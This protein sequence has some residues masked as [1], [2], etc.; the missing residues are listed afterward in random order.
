MPDSA[1]DVS[2]VIPT[3][4]RTDLLTKTVESVLRQTQPPRE[5]I[6]VD[7]GTQNRAAA[8]L[9][10]FGDKVRLARS[11]PSIKQTARNVGMK[12]A[13]STWVATLD[14][15]DLL[16]PDY[17][18]E[19][20][21]PMRDGRADI[22]SSDHRKFRDK[23]YETKTNFEKAPPGYWDDV[24]QPSRGETWAYVGK[25]PLDRLLKRVPVYPSTMI[26]RRDFALNIGGY[27]PGM[28]GIKAEDLEF[29]IRALTHGHLALVWKPL[30]HY[31][32]HAGNDSASID[33]QAIG[34][35][36]IFEFARRNHPDL[37]SDFVEA[38]DRNL[39]ERRRRVF[40]IAHRMQDHDAMR[41]LL[42]VLRPAD[43]IE[44]YK[45][46]Y[47]DNNRALMQHVVT[48]IPAAAW[49]V[50]LRARQFIGQLPEPIGRTFHRIM[51][52]LTPPQSKQA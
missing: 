39:P 52:R 8:A 38:L 32:L 47:R 40:A 21:G 24:P 45:Q 9:A 10:P 7:N 42:E 11:T 44:I 5:I 2:F 17:L 16:T 49:T 41:D 33:G 29:L 14:D 48:L 28:L 35:W 18:A 25:F 50:D 46:A 12:L 19:M 51:R 37:P 22:I 1:L 13:V 31:R 30:V 26:I 36:R 43:L 23:A 27:D 15:D 6:I 3:H 20:A 34:R 4:D